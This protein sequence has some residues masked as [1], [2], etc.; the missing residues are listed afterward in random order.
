MPDNDT[1]EFSSS[2]LSS[3]IFGFGGLILLWSGW[4]LTSALQALNWDVVELSRQYML[5]TGMMKPLRTLVDF[6]SHIKGIE[7]LIC[8]A[9]FVVFPVFFKYVNKEKRPV[10]VFG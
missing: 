1:K 8:V 9:F 3:I 6:Y 7:Y 2:I 4:A 5:T 10:K